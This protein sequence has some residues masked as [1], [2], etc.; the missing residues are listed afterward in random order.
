M[1][2]EHDP[3]Y[4]TPLLRNRRF[5]KNL[6]AAAVANEVTTQCDLVES[7]RVANGRIADLT[8]KLAGAAEKERNYLA[9]ELHDDVQ[10][11]LFGLSLNMA[12]SQ[13]EVTGQ[14]PADV[15]G[16]WMRAVQTAMEH[17][18]E[19]T[20]VLRTLAIDNLELPSAMRS[21]VETLPLA[22]N[23][24]ILFETD[25]RIGGL[26]P[27][28]ATACFR[29]LQEALGNAIKHSGG[30]HLLVRLRSSVNRLTVSIR[31]DGVGFDVKEARAHAA[32][33]GSIGLSSMRERAALAGGHFGI[34]SA[35]GHGTRIRASFPLGTDYVP[36]HQA[37]LAI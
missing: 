13:G 2:M 23:Q 22:P 37:A 17:L 6:K 18:H 4:S 7:L 19:L 29:I 26:T 28:V 32:G 21:Y 12:A 10:Q 9:G 8:E 20:V 36:S 16:G 1:S 30:T 24:T 27:D 15:I 11:I 25:A 34:Q 5:M 35:V 3:K 31:D 14:P 33:V